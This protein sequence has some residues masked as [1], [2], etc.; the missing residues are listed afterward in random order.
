M[1]QQQQPRQQQ[2]LQQQQAEDVI[3]WQNEVVL[4]VLIYAAM[5]T[6]VVRSF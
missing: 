3:D 6:N 5:H 2:L 1:Q 4:D